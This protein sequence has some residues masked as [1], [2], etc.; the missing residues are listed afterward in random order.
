MDMGDLGPDSSG[1]DPEDNIDDSDVQSKTLIANVYSNRGASDPEAYKELDDWEDVTDEDLAIAYDV[2]SDNGYVR[3]NIKKITS[4]GDHREWYTQLQVAL[5]HYIS[6]PG[7]LE[8]ETFGNEV[9][10]ESEGAEPLLDLLAFE[11]D[12]IVNYL[13]N[14]RADMA[15][16]VYKRLDEAA[17]NDEQE[18]E[19]EPAPADDD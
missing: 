5:A 4:S 6:G 17:D 14:G 19:E 8:E 9:T 7:R 1:N 13:L 10:V 15:E 2:T 16:E 12:H 3:D 18:A 11:A